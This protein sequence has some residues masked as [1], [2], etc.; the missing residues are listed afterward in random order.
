VEITTETLLFQ[1]AT[2]ILI[3]TIILTLAKPR[4]ELDKLV[5]LMTIANLV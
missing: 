1:F 5:T 3:A 2:K 4:L